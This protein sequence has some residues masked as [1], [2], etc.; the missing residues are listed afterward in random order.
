MKT[1]TIK[2]RVSRN[3][4]LKESAAKLLLGL[5]TLIFAFYTV[6]QIVTFFVKNF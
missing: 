4:K 3:K 1:L 6:S 5:A 2:L